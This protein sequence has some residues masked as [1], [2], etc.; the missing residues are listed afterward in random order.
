[1]NDFNY[2]EDTS[3]DPGNLHEEWF[4][5]SNLYWRYS[6]ALAKANREKKK[7]HEKVKW[8]RSKLVLAANKDPQEVMGVKTANQ[9]NLD[10]FFRVQPDYVNLKDELIEKEYECEMLENAVWSLQQKKAALENAVQLYKG[11]YFSGPK[12]LLDIEPGKRISDVR[13]SQIVEEGRR[14]LNRRRRRQNV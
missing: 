2:E 3:I 5:Q 12:E 10:A 7:L 11:E 6:S 8:T 13:T 4:Q 9:T 1:M 14:A